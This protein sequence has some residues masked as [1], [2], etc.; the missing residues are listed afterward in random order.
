LAS[1]RARLLM[2]FLILT[3]Y[4]PPEIGGAQTRLRSTAAELK[5]LGHQVEVVTALPN[6]PRGRIFPGYRGCFYRCDEN[7]GI[8]VHRVWIYAAMGGGLARVLNYSSFMIT[9]FFGLMRARKPDFI[10]VESPP[11]LLSIPAYIAGLFWRVPY[12]F[13]VADLWPDIILQGG[14]L[15]PGLLTRS[16]FKLEQWSYRKAEYVNVV[17]EGLRDALLRE[18]GVPAEKVLFLPNGVDTT[19]YQLR[20]PDLSL[21]RRLGL[22][23]K[24]IILWAGTLGTA[25]GLNYVLDA[26]N[27]LSNESQIHFLFVG[28]GSAKAALEQQRKNMNL[29]SVTFL[30]PV[31]IEELPPYFSIAECGLASL[32]PIPLYDGARPSKIFPILASSK[33]L[34]FV[35]Q[36]ETARLVDESKAGVVVPPEDPKA[37]ASAIR[38]LIENP[39]LALE[40]GQNGRAFVEEHLQWSTLIRDWVARLRPVPTREAVRAEASEV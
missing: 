3:Q 15:E 16:L 22:D 11:P 10:F 33:P 13:N 25:H 21:K 1:D 8:R 7:E 37:L 24:K 27:L 36:G 39:K 38:L 9:S 40:F 4:F 23:G 6:Y 12:I 28:D 14:F 34:I 17:T 30:D 5:R 29:H 35:G 32:L 2:K 18:K 20:V 26:A 31:S 19:H